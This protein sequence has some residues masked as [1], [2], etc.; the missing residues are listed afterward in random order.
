MK[1]VLISRLGIVVGLCRNMDALFDLTLISLRYSSLSVGSPKLAAVAV[2]STAE[3]GACEL[4]GRLAMR[5]DWFM[6]SPCLLK[7]AMKTER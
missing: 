6:A 5:R 2:T 3:N 7:Q 4:L 1:C